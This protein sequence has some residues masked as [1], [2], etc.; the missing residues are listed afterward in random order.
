M[1]RFFLPGNPIQEMDLVFPTDIAHQICRVLRMRIGEQVVVLDG[2]GEEFEVEL[3]Q[4]DPG[5]VIG[6]VVSHHPARGEPSTRLS[7]YL[8]LTQREKFEWMLQKCSEVGVVNFI[9]VISSR[10]LVQREN[11]PVRRQIRWKKIV[12][13]AAEQSG[14]GIVPEVMPPMKLTDAF[15]AALAGNDLS[16]LL[17]EQEHSCSLNDALQGLIGVPSPGLALFVGPEGGFSTQEVEAAQKMGIHAVTLGR[18]ILRMETAAVV[19]SALALH[20]LGDMK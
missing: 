15:Q 11:D 4:V 13:E 18:R 6:K 10:S 9:P 17:W 5:A 1:H 14:R 19:A 20:I 12:R 8:G 3:T 16:M 7:L 2:K